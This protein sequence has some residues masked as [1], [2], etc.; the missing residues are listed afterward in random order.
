MRKIDS[1]YIQFRIS[2]MLPNASLCA[3]RTVRPNKL[4]WSLEQS[5]F[6]CRAKQ[7]NWVCVRVERPR[8]QNTLSSPKSFSKAILFFFFFQLLFNGYSYTGLLAQSNFKTQVRDKGISGHA[9]HSCTVLWLTDA[10][11]TGWFTLSLG[12][13]GSGVSLS[14][15]S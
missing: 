3:W 14:S 1:K 12:S 6:Y 7:E 2:L 11:V 4:K 10:G 13:H 9:A 15:G 5:E 8:A